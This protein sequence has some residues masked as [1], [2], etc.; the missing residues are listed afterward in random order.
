MRR[1][2]F[3]LPALFL[4]GCLEPQVLPLPGS[5]YDYI[6]A[7]E[8]DNSEDWV[9]K[10]RKL[11]I[12]LNFEGGT[13]TYGKCGKPQKDIT[14]VKYADGDFEPWDGD[15]QQ[16]DELVEEVSLMWEKFDAEVTKERPSRGNY[17]MVVMSKRSKYKEERKER[18]A[19]EAVGVGPLDCGNKYLSDTVHV[20]SDSKRDLIQTAET[21]SHEVGHSLG[22]QHIIG[23]LQVMNAPSSSEFF[24]ACFEVS[25]KECKKIV[26]DFCPEGWINQHMELMGLIG[27]AKV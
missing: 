12:Y 5:N 18:G 9:P 3:C 6:I 15:E 26:W 14:C 2:I 17:V 25:K 10:K 1:F 4:F 8:D 27:P 24:D 7:G 11:V 16:Q 19:V 13:L 22:L 21:I 20:M 23:E